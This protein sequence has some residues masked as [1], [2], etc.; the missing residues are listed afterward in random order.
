ML[1]S[2]S[3]TDSFNPNVDLQSPCRMT[4]LVD[5]HV[6]ARILERRLVLGLSLQQ[7]ASLIGVTYQQV[8]KYEKGANRITAGRLFDISQALQVHVAWFF[9]GFAGDTPIPEASPKLRLSMELAR[10]FAAISN[11]K[12]KE[13][14]GH[15]ARALAAQ[16]S[17]VDAL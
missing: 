6:G 7:L 1:T 17:L 4:A 12:H 15:F 5:Q 10:N 16:H 14:I 11:E 9:E 3:S 13:A 8:H 2:Q